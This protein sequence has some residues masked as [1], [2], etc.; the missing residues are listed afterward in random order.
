MRVVLLGPPGAG[1]GTQALLIAQKYAIPHI[2]TGEMLREQ[3]AQQSPLGIQVK[4]TLDRGELV[5]DELIMQIV[6]ERLSRPDCARGFLLD[7]IPR[8]LLQSEML[9]A[10]LARMSCPLTH[11]VQITVPQQVIMERI[12]HRGGAVQGARTDD[13]A[14]V[15][16]HRYQVYLTQTAPLAAHYKDQ[17]CLREV[18]GVGTVDE[19]FERVCTVLG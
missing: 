16:A 14:E 17:G 15:A 12:R 8:T 7:G 13:S 9:D 1:K 6:H 4:A 5:A 2:S 19:V 18:D 10:I 3:V 11:V